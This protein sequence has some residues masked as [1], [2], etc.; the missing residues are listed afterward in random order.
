L[1]VAIGSN[2]IGS[3]IN[4]T[5]SIYI[6]GGPSLTDFNGFIDEVR[7]SNAPLSTES[8]AG[9]LYKSFDKGNDSLASMTNV[10][11]N[12]DGLLRDN[13]DDGGPKLN[14]RGD[15][16]FS[17]PAN[18]GNP[19]SPLNRSDA[20]SFYSGYYMRFPNI[21]GTDI[22]DSLMIN[23]DFNIT[24]IN[25]YV[26]LNHT[27]SVEVEITLTGPGGDSV[28]V[29]NQNTTNS[30]DNNVITVFD[31]NADSSLINERY[32]SFSPTVRP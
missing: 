30:A 19:V 6:G 21:S 28:K 32:V 1:P 18:T 7:I 8:I 16:K 26:G 27:N 14:L 17:H 13:A 12:F 5:D 9:S 15:A 22:R 23:A 20:G 25:L 2:T 31:D 10:C 29:F 3:I 11:Y 24:D 4:S